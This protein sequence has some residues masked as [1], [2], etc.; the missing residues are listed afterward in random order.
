MSKVKH[1]AGEI[2]DINLGRI[3]TKEIQGHE[4]G[5]CRP[6]IIVKA[7]NELALIYIVPLTSKTPRNPNFYYV[8]IKNNALTSVSY[9]LCH[10]IRTVSIKRVAQKRG[11]ISSLDLNK[12]RFVLADLLDL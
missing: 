5:K 12:I 7:L 6:C 10:Q 1:A 11:K 8:E 2:V 3:N 9:A 4:Q